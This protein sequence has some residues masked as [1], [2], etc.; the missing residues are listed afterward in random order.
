MC[1]SALR[2][3]TPSRCVTH[4]NDGY[5]YSQ[6]WE[7]FTLTHHTSSS[8]LWFSTSSLEDE[9]S[10]HVGKRTSLYNQEEGCRSLQL[11]FHVRFDPRWLWSTHGRKELIF[12]IGFDLCSPYILAQEP[13]SKGWPKTELRWLYWCCS[14]LT[15]LDSIDFSEVDFGLTKWLLWELLWHMLGWLTKETSLVEASYWPP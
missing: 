15:F 9:F 13:R 10:S 4:L 6:S 12:G 5:K 11:G 14:A 8:L 2:F 3:Y 7:H 1:R